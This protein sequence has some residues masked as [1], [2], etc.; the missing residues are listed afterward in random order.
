MILPNISDLNTGNT[1]NKIHHKIEFKD[2]SRKMYILLFTTGSTKNNFLRE[3]EIGFSL[4]QVT[5]VMLNTLF[6]LHGF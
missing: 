4:K 6:P 3:A 2:T 1:D 5:I